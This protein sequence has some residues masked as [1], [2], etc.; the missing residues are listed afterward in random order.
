MSRLLERDRAAPGFRVVQVVQEFSTAGGAETV[1]YQLQTEWE[2]DGLACEVLAGSVDHELAT[3]RRVRTVSARALEL[4]PTRGRWRY[5]G[6][7]LVVP[8]FTLVASIA[9][10]LGQR[11]GNW[12]EGAVIL[13]HGDC[14]VADVIVLHAVNAASLAQ[15]R[16]DGEWRWALNPMNWF[17]G[18][19]DRLLLRGLRA[20]RYVA[21]SKRV[22]REAAE[23]HR[24]PPDRV[25]VIPN[26]TDIERFT[27]QGDAAPF[28]AEFAIPETSPLLLFAGHEFGRKGLTHVIGALARPGCEL[29]HLVVVGA[30]DPRPYVR[31]ATDAGV[32]FTGAFRRPATRHACR[33]SG[34]RCI[35]ISDGVRNVLPGLHGGDGLRGASVRGAGGRDRRLPRRRPKWLLH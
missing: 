20:R 30:D 22:L 23:F 9:V 12:A 21:V 15:K 28:R 2:R 26:G 6:R 31:Q 24:I 16:R 4:V 27:P 17:V 1:A 11:A 32:E 18:V 5:L 34:G 35:R 7:A 14:L 25:A 3:T 19:R 8:W 29:A 13:S 10:S 33:V